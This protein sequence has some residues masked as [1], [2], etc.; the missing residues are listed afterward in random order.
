MKN[1][2]KRKVSGI[3]MAPVVATL[4]LMS[5][6]P[7]ASAGVKSPS[8]PVRIGA[9]WFAYT[10]QP[11]QAVLRGEQQEAKK[12]G[13]QVINLDGRG[14]VQTQAQQAANLL[15]QHVDAVILNPIDPVSIVPYVKKFHDAGIPVIVQSL[16]LP[17]SAQKYM[18]SFVG[19]D[20]VEAGRQC[21]QLM[22][23]AL[24]PQGGGVVVLEG[25]PGS[26]SSI[27]R[28]QGFKA[29]LQG[30]NI[31]ILGAQTTDWDRS[32]AMAIM[33]DFLTKYP[34]IQ[35]VFAEDD[36]VAMG[37]LQA[38]RAA[39]KIRQIKVIG[40]DG[41]KEAVKAIRSGEMYGTVSQPL[42][43]EGAIDVRLALDALNGKKVPKWYKV[44]MRT[45]TKHTLKGYVPPY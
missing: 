28:F 27:Q 38:I 14:D 9:L 3:A 13:V 24:G 2:L 25:A 41:S 20:G 7:P 15:V 16:N 10:L 33:Q 8:H 37:A 12:L 22:K 26:S 5:W 19:T 18:T 45:L 17:P 35:G 30:S 43:E 39:G 29:A 36:D 34:D 6:V 1:R 44:K 32:K 31:K 11:V 23:K 40:F 4:G 42:V 21:A